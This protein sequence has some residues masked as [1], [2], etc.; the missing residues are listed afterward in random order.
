MPAVFNSVTRI[1]P[2][3]CH[4]LCLKVSGQIARMQKI[5]LK[6]TPLCNVAKKLVIPHMLLTFFND[7]MLLS[8]INYFFFFFLIN[9]CIRIQEKLNTTDFE[10]EKLRRSTLIGIS[11]ASL[12]RKQAS[13]SRLPREKA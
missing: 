3:A 7:Y 11:I 13:A 1:F 9:I 5:V 8:A 2:D 6:A 10:S 12:I 4:I